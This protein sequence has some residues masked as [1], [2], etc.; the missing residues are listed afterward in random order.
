MQS[1]LTDTAKI[2]LSISSRKRHVYCSKCLCCCG[3]CDQT[4][5]TEGTIYY[6]L[7]RSAPVTSPILKLM[8]AKLRDG[9]LAEELTQTMLRDLLYWSLFTG[10]IDMAKVFLLHIRTRICAALTCEAI[11]KNCTAQ[12]VTND[13]VHFF[14][15]QAEDFGKYATDCINACYSKSEQ[16]ACELLICQQPLFGHITC[17]QVRFVLTQEIQSDL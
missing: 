12:A 6:E 11:L 7:V 2:Y 8:N 5:Y 10:R 1:R 4:V 17:M 16:K 3:C 14:K 13:E 9:I 15:Q